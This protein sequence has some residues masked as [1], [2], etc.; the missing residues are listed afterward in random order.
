MEFSVYYI[1]DTKLDHYYTQVSRLSDKKTYP[2]PDNQ[3]LQEL[4]QG[5]INFTRAPHKVSDACLELKTPDYHRYLDM[6]YTLKEHTQDFG[7]S[8]TKKDSLVIKTKLSLLVAA[9][10]DKMDQCSY[11]G[12]T[13]TL[14]T[15]LKHIPGIIDEDSDFAPELLKQN[16]L[17]FLRSLPER[18][19][20]SNF[21]RKKVTTIVLNVLFKIVSYVDGL[22]S[23]FRD[24]N[25]VSW[26][27]SQ[28]KGCSDG[29]NPEGRNITI[30]ILYI[31][32]DSDL[33]TDAGPSIGPHDLAV[34]SIKCAQEVHQRDKTPPFSVFLDLLSDKIQS[35]PETVLAV[36]R[37]INKMLE[38][39]KEADEMD[40][41]DDLVL[42]LLDQGLS[43]II[44]VG[45]HG[46]ER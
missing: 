5:L 30:A 45:C 20:Y 43:K 31:F 44:E 25:T 42:A 9:L 23:V 27:Y 24:R 8:I 7:V 2:L 22:M 21:D 40:L 29:R 1:D 10:K 19:N 28:V 16:G 35:D 46:D 6:E 4:L 26:L 34:L 11:G 18:D 37:L 41:F 17:A 13:R 12:D 32:V 36:I 39:L 3:P 14:R 38:T 33:D 15:I